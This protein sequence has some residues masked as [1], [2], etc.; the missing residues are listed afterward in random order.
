MKLE[1][2]DAFLSACGRSKCAI[3]NQFLHVEARKLGS[4]AMLV[5]ACGSGGTCVFCFMCSH[6]QVTHAKMRCW[7]A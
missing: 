7:I 2:P 4:P 6:E 5:T 1:T 3:E